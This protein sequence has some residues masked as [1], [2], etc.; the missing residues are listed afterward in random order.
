MENNNVLILGQQLYILAYKIIALLL[1]TLIFLWYNGNI[2][3][4]FAQNET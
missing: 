2:D 4:K 3:H 1:F